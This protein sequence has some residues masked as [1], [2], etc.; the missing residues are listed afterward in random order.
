MASVVLK[1]ATVFDGTGSDPKPNLSVLIEGNQIAGVGPLESLAV[2]PETEV[3][4]LA[5]KFVMPGMFN[6]HAHLGWDGYRDLKLQGMQDSDATTTAVVVMN[7]RRS[8]QA[9]LTGVR[10]LGMNN[11]G[12]I[13]KDVQSR[14]FA[15]GPR[16]YICGKAIC[17][18]GGHTWWCCH[19]ADGP[20]EMRRAVRAQLRG[21]AAVIKIM[22]SERHPQFTVTELTAAAEEAHTAGIKITAHATIPKAI[23]N[24]LDA[25]FDCI[26]HG[27]P[28]TEEQIDRLLEGDVTVVPTLSPSFLQAERG[29]EFGMS[30]ADVEARRQRVKNPVNAHLTGKA[31]RAGVP[32]AFG[33]DAGSPAVP[34]HDIVDEAQLLLRVGVVDSVKD[35]LLMATRNSARLNGVDDQLGTLEPGKLADVVVLRSD[36]FVDA[37]AIGRVDQLYLD[38]KRLIKDGLFVV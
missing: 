25:G 6:N 24:V 3:V 4:E 5:G 19:E 11:A 34:H 22:A 15:I 29:L 32:L 23:D 38:G 1:N 31:G 35:V 28:F 37:A 33:T 7:M 9:G 2:T 30:L 8:L 27:G 12:F 26:E 20:D 14:G 17:M 36:P 10:D 13:A 21:G 16:L 18:T